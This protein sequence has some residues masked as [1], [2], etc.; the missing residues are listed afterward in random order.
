MLDELRWKQQQKKYMV[1]MEIESDFA[2]FAR[3][4]T[5]SDSI[6]FPCPTFTQAK[7]IFET[8]LLLASV[9]VIPV[10]V[11][12]CKPIRFQPFPYNNCY[13]DKRNPRQIKGETPC[14]LK[15][16]ILADV[17]FKLYAV[18]VNVDADRVADKLSDRAKRH[19]GNN[20][21]H[22]Y[23]DIFN[24]LLKRGQ[25]TRR[26]C[27]GKSDFLPK[28]VGPLR[29]STS[30]CQ[31]V[32]MTIPSMPVLLYDELTF[33]RPLENPIWAQNVSIQEGVLSYEF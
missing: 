17:C 22:A 12:I 31:E 3:P 32:T 19:I 18:V 7:G 33:G 8:I 25:N 26:P 4:D 11:E 27:L 5:G 24:K 21:A 20:N 10:R 15:P 1:S 28:Y 14:Q 9:E 30:P 2:D 16:T 13:S 6:S 29:N 23:M